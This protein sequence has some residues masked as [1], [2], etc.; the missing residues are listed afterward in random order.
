MV[1][2]MRIRVNCIL[3]GIF[4]TEMTT[5]NN[6]SNENDM[7]KYAVKASKRSTAGK[8]TTSAIDGCCIFLRTFRTCSFRFRSAKLTSQS[9]RAGRPEEIIGP[10][11]MLSSKAGAYMNGGYLMVDGGRFMVVTLFKSLASAKENLG[12]NR[13][14]RVHQ[15]MTGCACPERHI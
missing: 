4:P 9:G 1:D 5:T 7:N 11:L 8:L 14:Y 6:T 10:C 2:R 13:L 3:P 15:S 12:S